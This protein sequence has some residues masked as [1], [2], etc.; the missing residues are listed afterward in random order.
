MLF[1]LVILIV[2]FVI[3]YYDYY[4]PIKMV[5]R[6]EVSKLNINESYSGMPLYFFG[7][8]QGNDVVIKKIMNRSPDLRLKD[9]RGRTYLHILAKRKEINVGM[10]DEKMDNYV[11]V[12]RHFL[13]DVN[14]DKGRNPLTIAINNENERMIR[15]LLS[16]DRRRFPGMGIQSSKIKRS[17]SYKIIRELL[18]RPDI[19]DRE[20]LISDSSKV[21]VIKHFLP[22]PIYD[23]I[24][25][26]IMRDL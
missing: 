6:G 9:H 18:E 14:D 17:I 15:I 16:L 21:E 7:L 11:E 3:L 12:S 5:K 2:I 20:I 22:S 23:E 10:L 8:I 13:L 4:H 1:F 19:K 24:I 26:H 25:P